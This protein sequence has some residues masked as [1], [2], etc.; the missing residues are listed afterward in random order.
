MLGQV[1][2]VHQELHFVAGNA[3][4]AKK[5]SPSL[6]TVSC[7]DCQVL[8]LRFNTRMHG[9]LFPKPEAPN[10]LTGT[11]QTRQKQVLTQPQPDKLDSS[12]VTQPPRGQPTY[13]PEIKPP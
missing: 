6:A 11:P 7:L 8:R 5:G 3:T 12:R 9:A 4:K 1:F 13:S 10:P 2:W